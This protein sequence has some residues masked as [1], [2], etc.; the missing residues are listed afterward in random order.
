MRPYLSKA[1]NLKRGDTM[2]D[3]RRRKFGN[4]PVVV[5][6]HR[7]ASKREARRYAELRLLER[8]G[9]ISD[10]QLQPRFPITVNGLTICRYFADFSYMRDGQTV[11]EDAKGVKTPVYKL[12]KKLLKAVCG[13]EVVEV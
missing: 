12:K 4:E 6:G 5:D 8:K 9:A 11:V 2:M 1:S 13:L 3:M 10:L 7:F